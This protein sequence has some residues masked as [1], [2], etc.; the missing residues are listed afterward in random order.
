MNLTEMANANG[1]QSEVVEASVGM[2][3]EVGESDWNVSE[4]VEV[5]D[6]SVAAS[7]D[8][9]NVDDSPLAGDDIIQGL[10]VTPLRSLKRRRLGDSELKVNNSQSIVD[11]VPQS[12]SNVLPTEARFPWLPVPDVVLSRA[13]RTRNGRVRGYYNEADSMGSLNPY[14]K[15]SE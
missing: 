10:P 11:V 12:Q 8:N 2:S 1:D 7:F 6:M 13:G 15:S 9:S 3:R 14:D 5:K 4:R